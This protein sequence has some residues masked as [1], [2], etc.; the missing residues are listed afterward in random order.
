MRHLRLSAGLATIVACI[1][2]GTFVPAHANHDYHANS[3]VP[4]NV[5]HCVDRNSLTTKSDTATK[6]GIAQLNRTKMNASLG[7]SG[8]VE[9]Y[10]AYY[11][12][13]GDWSGTVG[14]VT[15]QQWEGTPSV[16]DVYGMQFNLSYTAGYGTTLIEN[17]GCHEFGHTGGLVAWI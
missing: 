3:G 5:E 11:G 12:T 16:C 10:D 6:H 7:C 14:Q 8:D 9:V 15:C 13:S 1:A 4:D 17:T 2:S